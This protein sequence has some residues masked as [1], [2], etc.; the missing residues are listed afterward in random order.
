ME[1]MPAYRRVYLQ[2]KQQIKDGQYVVGS[3][4]PTETELEALYSVSRT[5]IR[6]AIGLL[7]D[8]GCLR[9][10]QGRGSEVLDTATTQRLNSVS[11]VTEALLSKGYQVSVLGMD[12]SVVTVPP[13]IGEKMELGEGVQVFLL[14]RVICAEDVPIAFAQNYLNAT[15]F[16]GFY[17]CVEEFSGLYRF[18]EETYGVVIK[19]AVETLSAVAADFAEA[20]ILKVP[21]GAPLL[22]SK[23]V[24]RTDEGPMEYSITKLVA[25]RYEYSMYMQGRG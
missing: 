23:R 8:D 13:S 10:Q 4:L 21:V 7:V 18:L 25:D 14:Q 24:T 6:K 15:M 19:E 11:S 22:C 17:T 3:L 1:K 9:V 5:T 16:P 2:L 12:I 20:Q